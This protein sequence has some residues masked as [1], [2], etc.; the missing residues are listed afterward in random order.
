MLGGKSSRWSRACSFEGLVD[1]QVGDKG[2]ESTRRST[3]R[4]GCLSVRQVSMGIRADRDKAVSLIRKTCLLFDRQAG[5]VDLQ[6]RPGGSL[7]GR[8]GAV[9]GFVV[10]AP[11]STSYGV[12]HCARAEARALLLLVD[13]PLEARTHGELGNL[14]R[15][16]LDRR[17]GRWISAR[18][19][20]A[21]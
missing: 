3:P 17:P 10:T 15:L 12:R 11:P 18:T 13:R 1:F 21:L 4:A 16:D 14:R 5:V 19:R 8:G 7:R 6:A 20:P 9:R 2:V